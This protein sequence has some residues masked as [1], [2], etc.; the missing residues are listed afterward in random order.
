MLIFY[1]VCTLLSMKACNHHTARVAN[2]DELALLNSEEL[3]FTLP[4]ER[5]ANNKIFRDFIYDV[6]PQ[7]GAIKKRRPL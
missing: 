4:T 1:I 7:V 2:T 5:E 3:V 6:R